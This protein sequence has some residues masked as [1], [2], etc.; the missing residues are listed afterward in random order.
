MTDS[1]QASERLRSE[2]REYAWIATY[3]FICLSAILFYKSTVVGGPPPGVGLLGLAA[4]KAL[5]LGKFALIGEAV[6]I[7]SRVKSGSLG[8][9]IRRKVILLFMLLLLLTVLEELL[10][11]W[12]HGH[13]LSETLGEFQQRSILEMLASSVLL[14]LVLTPYVA[15]KEIS[16][17]LG[18]GVLRA[19]NC[20]RSRVR[21]W[22]CH[23]AA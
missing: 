4:G 13:S 16:Q 19:P 7:G 1:K 2:L 17:S 15:V 11:G 14:L 21:S 5:I 9:Y 20:S 12:Y 8:Q 3:L 23:R 22:A 6:G 18:P 10:V